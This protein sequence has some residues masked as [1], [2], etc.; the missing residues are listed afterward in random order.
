MKIKLIQRILTISIVAFLVMF[1]E[2]NLS[3]STNKTEKTIHTL[4]TK[5]FES[6]YFIGY[7]VGYDFIKEIKH[8]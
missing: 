4:I 2:L 5:P 8:F 3:F 1:A 6:A 7:K